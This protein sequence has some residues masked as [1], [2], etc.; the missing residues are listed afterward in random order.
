[1]VCL[2]C[3][4][5]PTGMAQS[6]IQ[7]PISVTLD[8]RSYDY[9]SDIYYFQNASAVPDLIADDLGWMDLNSSIFVNFEDTDL[10]FNHTFRGD[11][12]G[13][14]NQQEIVAVHSFF[15]YYPENLETDNITIFFHWL[16]LVLDGEAFVYLANLTIVW[17][18]NYVDYLAM[19][20]LDDTDPRQDYWRVVSGEATFVDN[21]FMT[22]IPQAIFAEKAVACGMALG[23]SEYTGTDFGNI[24]YL[25]LWPETGEIG[26]NPN[27]LIDIAS[28]FT[29]L[30][31][32]VNGFY[33]GTFQTGNGDDTTSTT[34][35]QTPGGGGS[36]SS[37]NNS[38]PTTTTTPAGWSW[39]QLFQTFH[40]FPWLLIIVIVLV[41]FVIFN[42]MRME[43][44]VT[45]RRSPITPKRRLK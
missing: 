7:T 22:V 2:L 12:M 40:D 1:M 39:D 25:D 24:E 35:T 33:P 9:I 20:W 29:S 42:S 26:D 6:G 15:A 8:L 13:M 38:V 44:P 31:E 28:V 4:L 3:L 16:H 21:T 32:A 10:L 36:G 43:T 30:Q 5:L 19:E 41:I 34:T 14:A 18:L 11:L 45:T 37:S 27:L 23:I 17:D